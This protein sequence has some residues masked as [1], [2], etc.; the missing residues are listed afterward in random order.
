MFYHSDV[1]DWYSSGSYNGNYDTHYK[2][3][4]T[5]YTVGAGSITINLTLTSTGDGVWVNR[6]IG[7]GSGGGSTGI[8]IMEIEV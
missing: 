8:T 1:P 5:L 7:A 6:S 4:E 2:A 3:A